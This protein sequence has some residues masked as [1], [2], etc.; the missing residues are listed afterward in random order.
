MKRDKKYDS[1][2]VHEGMSV[3]EMMEYIRYCPPGQWP[4]DW[5]GWDN[6]RR[7]HIELMHEFINNI[8][9][10]P[11]GRWH[12]RGIVT[13]V[14][15]KP[16]LS[17][18]KNL[19]NGYLPSAWCMVNELRRHGCDLPVTFCYLGPLEWDHTLTRLVELLNVSVI[20]LR[21][22]EKEDHCRILAGWESKMY[23]VIHSPYEEVLFIDADNLPLR[24]PT[25]M[26]GAQQFRH[27][28]AIF[29]PDVPPY[30]RKEWLPSEVWANI[31]LPYFSHVRAAESGQMLIDKRSWWRELCLS[32]WLNE[33]SDWV[34]VW[35]FG[36]KDV[37][38]LASEKLHYMDQINYPL[39][40]F[41]IQKGAGGNH[42]SLIH[43]DTSGDALFQHL[44][45]NKP[46]INGFGSPHDILNRTECEKYLEE[47]R[48]LWSG[49]LWYND[50]PTEEERVLA[51]ALRGKI[52]EY[53]RLGLDCREM[54]F[55][56]EHRIG[57][58]LA[59]C[60]VDWS[61]FIDDKG[62]LLAISDID[63]LPT[64]LLRLRDDGSWYGQWLSYEQCEVELRVKS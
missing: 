12:G 56:E 28:G 25:Y 9:P 10:Y 60:E 47:L 7:A 14:N 33:H 37:G 16:G 49:R 46:T 24:D 5:H 42:S 11:E 50:R 34:Y 20:D 6:V 54:N 61:A 64:C 13:C 62:P 21:E 23:G 41:M 3:V 44:T 58:G 22:R 53:N 51:R 29:W 57:R 59:K 17:S 31:G 18:G 38:I 55:L 48:G 52:W 63:G 35:I 1:S 43:Y 15:A 45:R 26:F 30:D 39:R 36:D 32:R 8:P 2:R 4:L 27:Y 19:T 40:Y